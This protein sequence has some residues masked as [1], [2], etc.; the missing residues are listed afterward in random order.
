MLHPCAKLTHKTAAAAAA[1]ATAAAAKISA[2]QQH[3]KKNQDFHENLENDKI[4]KN[5]E[6]SIKID[7]NIGFG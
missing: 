5:I 7:E 3:Q 2:R 4:T 6:K 1:A